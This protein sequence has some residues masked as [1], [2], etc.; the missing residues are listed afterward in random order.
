M[1]TAGLVL[2][3]TGLIAS[4]GY[5]WLQKDKYFTGVGSLSEEFFVS[6]Y[7]PGER[8]KLSPFLISVAFLIPLLVLKMPMIAWTIFCLS[9]VGLLGFWL[10]RVIRK[11]SSGDISG[12]PRYLLAQFPVEYLLLFLI[13]LGVIQLL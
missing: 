12:V 11:E 9:L 6:Q 3:Y 1:G 5:L 8:A 4:F 2:L 10:Y 7:H 13:A